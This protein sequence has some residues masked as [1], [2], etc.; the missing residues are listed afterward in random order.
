MSV[1]MG[2]HEEPMDP[3]TWCIYVGK[4]ARANFQIGLDARTWGVDKLNKLNGLEEGDH[5]I[6]VERL[7]GFNRLSKDAFPKAVG[8]AATILIAVVT[9][10]V[11]EDTT[12]LWPDDTYPYRFRFTVVKEDR[13]VPLVEIMP[14]EVV[15]AI[16][17]SG[18]KQGSAVQAS[19]EVPIVDSPASMD[20]LAAST[21]MELSSLK[22]IEALLLEKHQVV[23]EGPPGSGKTY[24]ANKFARYFTGNPLVGQ[25]DNAVA[26]VQFHQSYGY[27]DF[28]QGIRPSTRP[29]GSLQYRVKPGMFMR[30]CQAAAKV[31]SRR[32]VLIIDEINRGNI[33]R[34]FG[35]LLF[36]LEYRDEE[37]RLPYTDGLDDSEASQFSIPPNVFIIGTM[38]S[39][40]RSL[41]LID[42]ALRRRFYFYRMLPVTNGNAPVFA[43]WLNKQSFEEGDRLRL[44]NLFLNLNSRIAEYLPVDFQ[45]GHSYFMS[46]DIDRDE[47]LERVW[48]HAVEPLL[49]E[50]FNNS[51]QSEEILSGFSI[52]ALAEYSSDEQGP[53]ALGR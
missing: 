35:E 53:E 40:D 48:R 34:I 20:E 23:L 17:L 27:E 32:H 11:Y 43:N 21:Y 44:L 42:Y 7:E 1:E 18:L 30:F 9:S 49:V 45:I 22:E 24:L 26:I 47:K 6:F 46:D 31:P 16:R 51:R 25:T 10:S 15:E 14:P 38:N 28:V 2:Q 39:T 36:L 37:V 12:P 19:L 4:P 8:N 52:A 29:D 41:A 5:V 33:S 3:N 50:Y 13:D